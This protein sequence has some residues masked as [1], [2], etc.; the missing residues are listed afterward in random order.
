MAL[1]GNQRDS[2]YIESNYFDA[3]GYT[4]ETYYFRLVHRGSGYIWDNTNEEL[5]ANPAWADMAISMTEVGTT[6]QYKV[7]IP[8]AVPAGIYEV[9]IHKQAGGSPAKEDDVAETH[10]SKIGSIFGF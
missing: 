4:G 8:A 10:E 6:G 1:G 7:E 3:G 2:S 5:A 9:V